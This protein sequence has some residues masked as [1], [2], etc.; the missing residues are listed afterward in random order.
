[1]RRFT[2]GRWAVNSQGFS[3]RYRTFVVN[4]DIELIAECYGETVE[5]AEANANL[6]VSALDSYEVCKELI[7][8]YK[9]IDWSKLGGV[10]KLLEKAKRAVDKVEGKDE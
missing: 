9:G 3:R 4:E 1:M 10:Q 6:I 7:E 2:R 5:E 8:M